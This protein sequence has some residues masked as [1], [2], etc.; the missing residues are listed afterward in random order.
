MILERQNYKNIFSTR[1]TGSEDSVHL[2]T[3]LLLIHL[4]FLPIVSLF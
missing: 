2:K 3:F 4:N 1:S